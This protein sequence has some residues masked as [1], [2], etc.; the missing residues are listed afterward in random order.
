MEKLDMSEQ[1]RIKLRKWFPAT[2]DMTEKQLKKEIK[3][4][5]RLQ[6]IMALTALLFASFLVVVPFNQLET[7]QK[8]SFLGLIVGG[9][10]FE[11]ALVSQYK[12]AELEAYFELRLREAL[13]TKA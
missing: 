10:A 8:M 6:L 3:S 4:N 13:A 7:F 9:M 5:K 2:K 1:L 11:F 12:A